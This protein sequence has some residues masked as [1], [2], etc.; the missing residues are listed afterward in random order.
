M[1]AILERFWEKVN[2]TEGG[3]WLWTGAISR[4]G[5]GNMGCKIDEKQRSVQAHRL[6]W[7]LHLGEIPTGLCVCHHCD[8][9]SCV[10][11]D[12][13]FLGTMKDNMQD[14]QRK[15]RM[16]NSC[17]QLRGEAHYRSKL[18]ATNVVEIRTRYR[19]TIVTMPMLASEYGVSRSTIKAV[20]RRENWKHLP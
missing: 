1:K 7:F 15:G 6:S 17:G 20:V 2:K 3:C 18:T 19:P 16:S 8:T 10:N 12:H 13:L 14:A 5:Y 4:N 9:P 11:P